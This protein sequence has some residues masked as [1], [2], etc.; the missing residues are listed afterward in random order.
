MTD[1]ANQRWHWLCRWMIA[2]A[3]CK[4][5]NAR[6]KYFFST[7]QI[8]V[9]RS[10][11]SIVVNRLVTSPATASIIRS[12]ERCCCRPL[13]T[14]MTAHYHSNRCFVVLN[15]YVY[16][17]WT[18]NSRSWRENTCQRCSTKLWCCGFWRTTTLRHGPHY[19]I[20]MLCYFIP[21]YS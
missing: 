6:T 9:T 1:Q 5:V 19:S 2:F 15:V 8:W 14:S 21:H 7:H 3:N 20:F 18:R 10:L 17:L 13:P 11:L 16:L 12:I 4:G